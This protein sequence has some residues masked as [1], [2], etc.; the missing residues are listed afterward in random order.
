M[1]KSLPNCQMS[2]LGNPPL[3]RNLYH[4]F[5]GS[6]PSKSN[7]LKLLTDSIEKTF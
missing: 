3:K 2:P 5:K 7:S 1:L 6:K 4:Q